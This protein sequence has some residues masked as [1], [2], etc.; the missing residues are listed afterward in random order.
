MSPEAAGQVAVIL[1]M[2]GIPVA[3]W[4]W[5]SL[6]QEYEQRIKNCGDCATCKAKWA[7]FTQMK[8]ENRARQDGK[9]IKGHGWLK[10][11]G[12]RCPVCGWS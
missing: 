6:T 7:A 1:V 11:E 4:A 2:I 3:A 12:R 8:R 10:A 9:C 5:F